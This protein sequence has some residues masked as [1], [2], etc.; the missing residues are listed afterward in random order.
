LGATASRISGRGGAI[1]DQPLLHQPADLELDGSFGGDFDLFQSLGVL[2]GA[3]GTDLALEHAEVAEFEAV[4][5]AQ[6][7]H[8]LVQKALHDALDQ[9]PLGARLLGDTIDQ[10]FLGHRGHGQLQSFGPLGLRRAARESR[11][12]QAVPPRPRKRAGAVLSSPV[13]TRLFRADSQPPN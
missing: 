1:T 11:P 2:R 9:D 4:A 10:L 5:L 6:F 13:G 3:G 8:D 7:L 12:H